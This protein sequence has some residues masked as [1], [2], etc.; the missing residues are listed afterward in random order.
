MSVA[1]SFGTGSQV[2]TTIIF[3]GSE[4]ELHVQQIP[5]ASQQKARCDHQH[6]REREFCDHQDAPRSRLFAG[7]RGTA[8]RFV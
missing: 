2:R 3:C 5:E 7:A 1:G 8:C 4:A 6:Q